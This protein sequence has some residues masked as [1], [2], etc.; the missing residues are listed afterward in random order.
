[1]I[2][3]LAL[4]AGPAA[5]QTAA[6]GFGANRFEPAERGGEWF[7]A[8]SLDF[9]GE[10]RPAAGFTL[11]YARR[12]LVLYD[13]A[14]EELAA[15]IENALYGH[16]GASLVLKERVRFGLSIPIALVQGGTD[17]EI[18]AGRFVAPTGLAF[19]DLRLA[20]DARVAGEAGGPLRLAVGAVLFVPSGSQASYTGD[21]GVHVRPRATLAGEAGAL[22][23]AARLGYHIRPEPR[24]IGTVGDELTVGAAVGWKG[25]EG[26]LLV[27]PELL[28]AAGTRTEFLSGRSTAAELILG[29]HL[30][31]GESLRFGVG[32][33]P[34]LSQAAGSPAFRVLAEMSWLG[35]AAPPD[36]D[37]DGV[38]DREDACPDRAGVRTGDPRTN[39]CPPPPDTDRDGIIDPE[40]ACP[41]QPGPRTSDPRTN[42]CPPPPDADRDTIIDGEDACPAEPGPRTND[43]RTNGCPPAP[44]PDRDKDTIPDAE[45][46]CPD[47]PGVR[48]G[49]PKTNGC[50]DRDMDGMFDNED[51]CPDQAGARDA[52]PKKNGCPVARLEADQI[53]IREQVKFWTGSAR[54][55]PESDAIITAVADVLKQHPE[56]ASLRVEGHTDSTGS[57]AYNLRL[58]RNRAAA[59]LR[60][61][62]AKG[63][64]AK[65]LKSAGF[66]EDKPIDSNETDDG[67]RNNRRVEFHVESPQK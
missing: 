65:R 38:P 44:P 24:S 49:D 14:G 66:G 30:M 4:A 15:P 62:V 67:R 8:D 42:G 61:L 60:A 12:P 40:D 56:I 50:A 58:S 29:G 7:G 32:A 3:L 52:D 51:A 46:A 18:D 57:N 53:V 55:L 63:I 2:A 21:G 11:D 45:D 19:G 59:V 20:A 17:G 25:L 6:E 27:G 9:R 23:Y 43:P 41:A 34:G 39:G 54:L 33:G 37:Q 5:A 31:A 28:I 48:T 47:H 26:R 10:L 36:R 35:S 13:L 16:L 64:D 22:A 1:M